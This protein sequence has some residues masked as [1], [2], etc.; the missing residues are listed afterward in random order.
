MPVGENRATA[1]TEGQVMLQVRCPY[2]DR[3]LS[4]PQQS[5]GRMVTCS[6]CGKPLTVPSLATAAAPVERARG[7]HAWQP[8]EQPTREEDRLEPWCPL[9]P[10]P[11]PR[12]G[13]CLFISP[14]ARALA[15]LP[16]PFPWL[17]VTCQP[18]GSPTQT[19]HYTQTGVQ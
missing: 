9:P 8:R 19:L 17:E 5:A 12:V 16:L 4:V 14:S 11:P 2:C 6:E 18:V 10:D 7:P 15:L 13:A 1:V 3:R